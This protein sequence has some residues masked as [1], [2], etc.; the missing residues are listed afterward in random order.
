MKITMTAIIKRQRACFYIHKK[1]NNV[2]RFYIQKAGHF[3]KSRQFPLGFY[4]QKAI[5]FRLL[6][7]YE[8]VEV[9]IYIQKA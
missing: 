3:Q 2:K 6:D 8:I 7:F 1:K 4:I 5:H 9:V